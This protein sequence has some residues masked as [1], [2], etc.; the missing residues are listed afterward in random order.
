MID[1]IIP[2]NSAIPTMES[3]VFH[4]VRDNQAEVR[5]RVYQ[6]D[7]R[8]A[9]SN[10]LLGEFVLDGLPEGPRGHAKVRVTFSI[11]ADG[12]VNVTATASGTGSTKEM[13]VESS[14]SLSRGEVDALRFDDSPLGSSAASSAE[15]ANAHEG[16][17][18]DDD[19]MLDDDDLFLEDDDVTG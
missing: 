10:H 4:T 7:S 5:I 6:G 13:R 8:D 1:A 16:E 3:K 15:T 12:M 17:V 9:R 11:D 14:S 2:R 18:D 19:L